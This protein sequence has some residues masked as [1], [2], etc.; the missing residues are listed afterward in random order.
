MIRDMASILEIFKSHI[1][2]CTKKNGLY[3][4]NIAIVNTVKAP[5]FFIRSVKA[6]LKTI[7]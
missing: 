5:F 1:Y 4:I 6:S 7:R 2:V 3:N